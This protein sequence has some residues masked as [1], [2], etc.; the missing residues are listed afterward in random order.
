MSVE[1]AT[2]ACPYG[3]RENDPARGACRECGTVLNEA[4]DPEPPAARKPRPVCPECGAG[5]D[6]KPAVELRGS[7]S[8][9]AFLAGGLIAVLF[10]N[11]GRERRVQW[12][13]VAWSLAS[14]RLR[15]NWLP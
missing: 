10:R 13:S 5:G 4:L 14:A 6:F 2:K 8:L 11:A 7:F 3:G 15:Q 1:T 12:P 9:L